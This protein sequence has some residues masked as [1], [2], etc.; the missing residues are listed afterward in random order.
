MPATLSIQPLINE[1]NH[2]FDTCVINPGK[3]AEVDDLVDQITDN[4]N[5]YNVV[6]NELSIP[7][8]FI[9]IIHYMESSL[10]FKTHLHNG[11]P[12]TKRT[13]NVPAGRP[14]TGK[15]PF[16]WEDSA[17]DALQLQ[18]LDVW[19][20]WSIAG[21]LYQMELYNGIGY[22]KRGIYSPYLWSFSNHYSKGKFTK[23][24]VYD[25]NA[26]SKQCGAAVLFRRMCE[27]QIITLGSVDR[28]TQ[29]KTFGN[30][31]TYNTKKYSEAAVQLQQLLNSIGYAVRVDGFAGEKTSNAFKRIAGKY[32]PGD[33]RRK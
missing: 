10:N 11:D 12:L 19:E 2:L 18:K 32:L 3:Y 8:Y 4:E 6:T 16:S 33:P 20:D 31:V 23:D 14:K 30:T 21:T 15:P 27:R 26:V 13:V 28:I 1:Y 29:I 7:W 25:A 5:R 9:G 17:I 24:G 22:R